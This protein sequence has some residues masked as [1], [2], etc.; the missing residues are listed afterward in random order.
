LAN[1]RY[2]HERITEM[3]RKSILAIALAS[4]F[5]VTSLGAYAQQDEKKDE[6]KPYVIS[7]SDEKKDEKN[8][9]QSDEKEP[10]KPE[11]ISQSDEKEPKKPELVSWR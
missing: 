11:L 1:V 10:K 8:T 7:Q 2:F 9:Y 4:A 5:A 6:K 3:K